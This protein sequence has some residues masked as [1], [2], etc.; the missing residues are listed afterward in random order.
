MSVEM[1]NCPLEQRSC[2]GTRSI[3][4]NRLGAPSL[5]A[6]K[7]MLSEQQGGDPAKPPKPPFQSK[8]RRPRAT[9]HRESEISPR[10]KSFSE[11][12]LLTQ[13]LRLLLRAL[14]GYEGA[15]ALLGLNFDVNS[16]ESVSCSV[17]LQTDANRC[18]FRR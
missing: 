18:G 2:L 12:T 10:C 3:Q 7:A 11:F 1:H 17:V 6:S 4:T 16:S 5:K 15:G 8:A 9:A 14:L 13:R